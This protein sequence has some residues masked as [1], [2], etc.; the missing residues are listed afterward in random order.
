MIKEGGIYLG[1]FERILKKFLNT[2]GKKCHC[3][4][5]INGETEFHK[6]KV[7]MFMHLVSD[8]GIAGG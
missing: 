4:H 2:R 7:P 5:I 1:D 6:G 8:D 3:D